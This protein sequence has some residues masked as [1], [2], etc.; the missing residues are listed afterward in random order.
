[1]EGFKDKLKRY[2]FIDLTFAF[3]RVLTIIGG[4]LWIYFSPV[5][6]ESK[7]TLVNIFVFF[8]V[9]SS[10]L[11]ALI[12][13]FPNKIRTLYFSALF[14]DLIFIFFIIEET[15]GLN[16]NFYLAFYL[17]IALHSF[18]YGL[19]TGIFVAL[20]SSLLYFLQG[21]LEYSNSI[22]WTDF[23]LRLSFF[24]LVGISLG[25]I[26]EKEKKDKKALDKLY[27]EMKNTQ[28]KLIQSEKM[29]AIGK[30]AAGIAHE[31][32]NPLDGIQNCV[33]AI[34]ENPKNT[35]LINRYLLL[36]QEGL[37]RIENT[38]QRLL[39]FAKPHSKLFRNVHINEILKKTIAL[40]EE[41][42]KITRIILKK[43]FSS[44]SEIFADPEA[45]NQVFLNIIL[46]SI[47]A[48]LEGGK[49]SITT[50]SNIDAMIIS[51]SDTGCGIPKENLDKIFDP[52]FTT[53]K[54]GK[55]TGL[56][57]AISLGIIKE[58]SGSITV[59]SELSK[60]S[61]FTIILPKNSNG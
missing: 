16:S 40:V 51:I 53:K 42:L 34:I 43:H 8:C 5:L 58:H 24:W 52:F 39:D 17:L 41:N 15:G 61:K 46:N 20:I 50:V 47:D 28:E 27:K 37:I 56:G 26:S 14:L 29:V 48:I 31:I 10:I 32:N 22:Y 59:E 1:M 35:E 19:K 36:V 6:L 11:Y 9:Y 23:G 60:G 21:G 49:I 38:V 55:G 18:Y 45:L 2:D 33:R 3:L 57:L 7:E 44:A 25:L 30:L 54:I 12:F 4:F 13:L